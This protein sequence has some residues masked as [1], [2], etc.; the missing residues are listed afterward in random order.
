M[1]KKI[2]NIICAFIWNK[3]KRDC[4]R[5]KL[6]NPHIQKIA[7]R[8][9]KHIKKLK[10]ID[11]KVRICFYVTENQ[12]WKG[13]VLFDEL[14]KNNLF[15]VFAVFA[16]RTREQSRT[17]EAISIDFDFFSN[18]L[19]PIHLG[20]DI[21]K[22]EYRNLQ[23]YNPD[24]VFYSQP[25]DIPSINSIQ[26]VSKYA[27]T[28]Y[29]P[30]AIAEAITP[31]LKNVYSFHYL[32]WR[33]YTAHE[34]INEQ[35]NKTIP[36]VAN[37]LKAV[38][39]PVLDDIINNHITTKDKLYD[40]CVIYAPHHSFKGSWLEYGTFDW[41]G[42]YI[43]EYAKKHPELNWVFRPHP[44]FKN[45]VINNEIMTEKEIE[46]YFKE[47]NKIGSISDKG[48]YVNL[49]KKSKCMITDCGSFITEYFVTQKPLIHL[50][51][52]NAKD[53]NGL[54]DVIKETLYKV[55]NL[56]ELENALKDILEKNDDLQLSNRLKLFEKLKFDRSHSTLNIIDDIIG[57]IK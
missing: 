7:N 32:L 12:K 37:N 34:L 8:Y 51:N 4:L 42:R 39:Y 22:N 30:Y 10:T 14:K 15:D 56:N 3:R 41:N 26:N 55:Y 49:F 31:M 24:I 40:N 53:Y 6:I 19:N 57:V 36:Y 25:W 16:P 18:K 46:N 48:N 13:Q 28:C 5:N 43:L 1:N 27:L 21:E 50:R 23:E 2:A 20:Y 29:I 9:K 17:Y 33:H 52:P 44:D 47:W 54:N 38:G 45:A 11:R 35:Y